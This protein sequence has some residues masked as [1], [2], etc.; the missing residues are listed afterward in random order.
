MLI[1]AY[2]IHNNSK[3]RKKLRN[4][5]TKI[6]FDNK[7]KLKMISSQ[8]QFLMNSKD[9]Q[10]RAKLF[11]TDFSRLNFDQRHKKKNRKF[12]NVITLL[13]YLHKFTFDFLFSSKEKVKVRIKNNFIENQVTRKHLN[14]WKDFIKSKA[15]YIIVFEDDV[16]SKKNSSKKLKDL[17][18]NLKNKNEQFL[19]IDLAGGYPLDVVIPKNCIIK[20]TN[21]QLIVEGI[22]TNTA[23]GYLV[24]KGLIINWIN[25][26]NERKII[27][28]FPIDFLMNYLGDAASK[29]SYSIHY[30]NPF[31]I[32]G[33][34]EG[35]VKSWQNYFGI[36][37][38]FDL[39]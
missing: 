20:E 7:I 4:D 8:E 25:H 18:F 21:N 29:K 24:S 9:L 19:Y 28:N 34:F 14:A 31:F 13:I 15:E 5:I 17:I 38:N 2:I 36:N 35:K 33:S 32:H 6:L 12:L 16:I 3:E 30:K 11:F 22:Y 1:K 23:C 26:L 39:K 37:N 10:N 27:N